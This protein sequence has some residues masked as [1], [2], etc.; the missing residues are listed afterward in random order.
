M[1]RNSKHPREGSE[2]R[3]QIMI[4]LI[5]A[6]LVL[7]DAMALVGL[8]V[9]LGSVGLVVGIASMLL[10]VVFYLFVVKPWHLRWG[11]TAAEVAMTMPGDDLLPDAKTA[12]RAITINATPEAVWP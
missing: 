5:V 8:I 1:N 11:A 10:L 12:T 3:T 6:I 7:V 4:G 2:M 9:W